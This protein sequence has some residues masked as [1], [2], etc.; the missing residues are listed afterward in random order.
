MVLGVNYVPPSPPSTTSPATRRMRWLGS[1]S[2]GGGGGI[3]F[4]KDDCSRSKL[5]PGVTP[6][7]FFRC[8]PPKVR[9]LRLR[10]KRPS[11]A[12]GLPRGRRGVPVFGVVAIDPD[13]PENKGAKAFGVTSRRKEAIMNRTPLCGRSANARLPSWASCDN[14]T[15][16]PW[17]EL[18]NSISAA[19]EQAPP[20]ESPVLGD[21]GAGTVADVP[22]QETPAATSPVEEGWEGHDSGIDPPE[23]ASS[24]V[25]TLLQSAVTSAKIIT[26][27]VPATRIEHHELITSEDRKGQIGSSSSSSRSGSLATV[28]GTTR[29]DAEFGWVTAKSAAGTSHRL[30]MGK[31][32]APRPPRTPK[33]STGKARSRSRPHG[34]RSSVAGGGGGGGQLIV[35]KSGS[36]RTRT[37]G[38][39]PSS[40]GACG[41]P[42]TEGC[43]RG[44]KR[45]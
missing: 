1:S 11:R 22:E 13:D 37:G 10:P 14:S 44:T 35:P 27:I 16:D 33:N 3:A 42:N 20:H 39:R 31:G 9:R 4:T 29:H 45:V 2:G 7:G 26:A 43:N 30:E 18:N 28:P 34:T 15:C 19:A 40:S 17:N 6:G 23:A 21:T 41:A 12:V 32:K 8:P 38:V 25:S 5:M 36:S 24:S